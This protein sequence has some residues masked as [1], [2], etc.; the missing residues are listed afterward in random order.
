M[1][2]FHSNLQHVDAHQDDKKTW[3]SL[4]LLEQL[5][6]IADELAKDA[7]LRAIA[8]ESFISPNF[9]FESIRITLN[10]KEVTASIKAAL[11]NAWGKHEG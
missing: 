1:P 4:T 2:P 8:T 5:N 10:D 9:P 11:F 7:L 6:M 3:T